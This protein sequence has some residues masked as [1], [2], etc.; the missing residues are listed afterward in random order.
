MIGFVQARDLSLV[1]LAYVRKIK[2]SDRGIGTGPAFDVVA[3][4]ERCG[5]EILLCTAKDRNHAD[6]IICR[7]ADEIAD[8]GDMVALVITQQRI[9]EFEILCR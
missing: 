1:N 3:V 9:G 4:D 6:A 2:A 5:D 8:N 7:I